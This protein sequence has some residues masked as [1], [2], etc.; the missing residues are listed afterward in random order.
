MKTKSIF[1]NLTV[2]V[3]VLAIIS[4]QKDGF[5]PSTV[6]EVTSL[7]QLAY[8]S[9]TN[10]R[11]YLADRIA[12]NAPP[13]FAEV[14]SKWKRFS[15]STYYP[16]VESIVATPSYCQTSM[17]GTGTWANSTSP[18]VNPNTAGAC[19]TQSMNSLSW[20]YL[21]S[22]D[23]LFNIQN[24]AYYNGFF[25]SLKFETYISETVVSSA[26]T[27]DDAIGVS[28]AVYVDPNTL[29]VHTL[30][31][32]RTQ[33]GFP[34]PNQGWGILYKLNGSVVQTFD[35]KSVGGVNPSGSGLGDGQGWNGRNS[36]IRIERTENIVKAYASPWGTG[37]IA[38]AIDESSLIQLDLSDPLNGLTMFL[39]AQSY[40]YESLSQAQATFSDLSFQTPLVNTDPDYLFDLRDNLV[41]SKKASGIGYELVPGAK[42]LDILGYPRIITNIETQNEFSINSS[43]SYNQL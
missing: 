2:A 8:G 26:G 9:S 12:G 21:T 27:D 22:P 37:G 35:N 25:S 42:A 14:V 1:K 33:G 13:K 41:Y 34:A 38:E 19:N 43:T 18:V 31:A 24:T 7:Y 39:G 28:I 6:V 16:T 36:N 30:S 4:C 17:D 5:A 40:G 11:T 3:L 23:R 15:G 10:D 20:I 29:D 32:Y